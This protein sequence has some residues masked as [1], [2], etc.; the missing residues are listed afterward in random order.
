MATIFDK[1]GGFAQVSGIVAAFYDKVLESSLLAPYFAGVD[2]GLLI[3]HQSKFLA[4]IMGGPAVMSNDELQRTH[5]GL[6]VTDA[7]FDEMLSLLRKTL[8]DFRFGDED[9]SSLCGEIIARR[10]YIVSGR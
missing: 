6:Q 7:A 8:E 3:V 4:Q 5:A 1:Y 2:M 9:I 10:A